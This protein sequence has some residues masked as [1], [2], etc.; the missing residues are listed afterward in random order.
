[1]QSTSLL[2]PSVAFQNSRIW[3]QSEGEF[4]SFEFAFSPSFSSSASIEGTSLHTVASS[5]VKRLLLHF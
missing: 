4:R 3:W 5:T 2:S 1:L